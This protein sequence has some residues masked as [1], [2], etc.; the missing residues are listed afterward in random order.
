MFLTNME[1]SL[2][3]VKLANITVA[4]SGKE[5]TQTCA[6]LDG[7]ISSRSLVWTD[8]DFLNF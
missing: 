7:R 6:L 8:L 2:Y 5:E 4:A 3:G 1:E